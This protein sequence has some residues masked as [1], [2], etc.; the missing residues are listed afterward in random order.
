MN[1]IYTKFFKRQAKSIKVILLIGI[2][3]FPSFAYS[4]QIFIK[5]LT[6]KTI[7]LDVEAS[8]SIEN[9]KAKIQDKESIPSCRQQLI[10]AGKQLEDGR[11]LA[12]YNIQKESTLHLIEQLMP[13]IAIRD[14]VFEVDKNFS[15]QLDT[16]MFPTKP[17]TTFMTT[18]YGGSLPYSI[19][20]DADSMKMKGTY[21]EAETL[22]FV[23]HAFL[24]TEVTDT[25]NITF[26]KAVPDSIHL[27]VN[28]YKGATI[29]LKVKTNEQVKAIKNE[30]VGYDN[31]PVQ[32]QKLL[33][34]DNELNDNHTIDQYYILDGDTL[35]FELRNVLSFNGHVSNANYKT[36][37][38]FVLQLSSTLFPIEPDSTYMTQLN[39]SDLLQGMMYNSQTKE[40]KGMSTVE[41]SIYIVLHAVNPCSSVSDTFRITFKK[42]VIT[43]TILNRLSYPISVY[44]NPVQDR[45]YI[46][47]SDLTTINFQLYSSEGSLIQNGNT[48]NGSISTEQLPAGIYLLKWEEAGNAVMLRFVK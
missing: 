16:A 35:Q 6:G 10:F 13:A 11:T 46:K 5:T 42:P 43:G 47:G 15:Y 8:D 2:F 12:D 14:T 4:M 44:P 19:T 31:V 45:L 29:L 32:C 1:S 26:K 9:V 20:Y 41:D 30:L 7:T 33:Y 3:C 36:H 18:V 17:D 21:D 24:C 48:K 37:E 38:N 39:G 23:F 28:T 40:L 25:F 22:T 34:H 27:F